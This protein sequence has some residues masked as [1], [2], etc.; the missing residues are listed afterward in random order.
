MWDSGPVPPVFVSDRD[1]TFEVGPDEL[2]SVMTETG[3]EQRVI[4][5]GLQTR[6][7]AEVKGGLKA[8]ERVLVNRPAGSVTAQANTPRTNAPRFN[9]GPQL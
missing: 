9:R 7:Q 8:G 4:H 1:W 5:I 2:W 6:T 3:R